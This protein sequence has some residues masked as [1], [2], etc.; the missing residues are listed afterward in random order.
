MVFVCVTS[1]RAVF[2]V[3]VPQQLCFVPDLVQTADCS[4]V[5][6]SFILVL[7]IFISTGFKDQGGV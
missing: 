2:Q 4:D 5:C 3:S 7:F 6:K 1:Q